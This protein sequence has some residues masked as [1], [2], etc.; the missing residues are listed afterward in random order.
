MSEGVGLTGKLGRISKD[1]PSQ[2]IYPKSISDR[3][4]EIAALDKEI[5]KW[6]NR[7]RAYTE[8]R[9]DGEITAEEYKDYRFTA[10]TKLNAAQKQ[11]DALFPPPVE[12]SQDLDWKKRLNILKLALDEFKE[13]DE[14]R[15]IPDDVI[16]AFVEKIV[17]YEEYTEWH[18]RFRPDP[19][20]CTVTG[21]HKNG[22]STP[23]FCLQHDRLLSRN[24]NSLLNATL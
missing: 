19:V 1:D 5:Q 18:L 12:D 11:K 3:G 10:E 2:K 17:V 7:I 14:T 9:A 15:K 24:C 13:L 4:T 6:K 20:K 21:S 8:M 23:T 16:D 22:D